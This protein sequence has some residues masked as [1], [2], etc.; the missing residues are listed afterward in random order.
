[1]TGAAATLSGFERIDDDWYVE[2]PA[3]V[4]DLLDAERFRGAVYDPA[5]G[6]GN[7][8]MCCRARGMTAHGSDLIYRGFGTGHHDFLTGAVLYPNVANIIMNP[9]FSLA[10][11]FIEKALEVVDHKVA[12]FTRLAFLEGQA[13]QKFFR[14]SPLSRVLVFSRRVR[15]SPGGVELKAS[16]GKVAHCWLVFDRDNR[17]PPTI[18]WL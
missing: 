11:A 10:Q 14:F 3:A 12:V 1:M 4:H 17:G 13:R 7:I 2:E 8:P 6:G 16:G 9:P 18:D 5:C 15:L